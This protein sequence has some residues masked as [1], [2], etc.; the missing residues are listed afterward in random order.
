MLK[1]KKNERYVPNANS[2]WIGFSGVGKADLSPNLLFLFLFFLG[3]EGFKLK[4]T[5]K[6][7]SCRNICE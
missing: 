6:C 4:A 2:I 7:C 3:K 1:K 5:E